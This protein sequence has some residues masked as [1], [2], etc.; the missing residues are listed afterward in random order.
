M[1]IVMIFSLLWV[2]EC[3]LW[4]TPCRKWIPHHCRGWLIPGMTSTLHLEALGISE[5]GVALSY[6]AVVGRCRVQILVVLRCH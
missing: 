6:W 3:G 1:V 2:A 4:L 5:D